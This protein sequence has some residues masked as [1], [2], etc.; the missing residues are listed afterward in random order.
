MYNSNQTQ[1]QK[2]TLAQTYIFSRYL[3]IHKAFHKFSIWYCETHC[4]QYASCWHGVPLK[5]RIGFSRK[6]PLD[7]ARAQKNSQMFAYAEEKVPP[8]TRYRHAC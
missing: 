4:A 8:Q 1:K 2:Q 6:I 3:M 7:S 5:Y